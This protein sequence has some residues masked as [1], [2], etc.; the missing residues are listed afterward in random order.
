MIDMYNEEVTIATNK[1]EMKRQFE[2]YKIP[3]YSRHI[4]F[5]DS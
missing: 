4:E 5:A 3:D 1:V 2:E